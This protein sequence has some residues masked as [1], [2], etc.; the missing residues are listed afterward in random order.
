MTVHG[1][2]SWSKM[3]ITYKIIV[4]HYFEVFCVSCV[5]LGANFCNGRW[6]TVLIIELGHDRQRPMFNIW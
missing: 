5:V 3:Y 1:G 2:I 4:Y 6:I